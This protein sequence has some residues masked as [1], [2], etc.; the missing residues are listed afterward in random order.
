MIP[1]MERRE[2]MEY[3]YYLTQRP[4]GPGCQPRKG[5]LDIEDLDNR[6]VPEIGRTA[7]SK[8]TYDR[9][10]TDEEIRNYELTESAISSH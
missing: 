5:L 1:A 10:L 6:F 4:A 8:V 9:Q 3:S 7:W 2:P